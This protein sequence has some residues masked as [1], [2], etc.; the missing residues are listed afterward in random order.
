[1]RGQLLDHP[2]IPKHIV[3]AWYE[4]KVYRLF[5]PLK[6]SFLLWKMKIFIHDDE[7]LY[8][9]YIILYLSPSRRNGFSSLHKYSTSRG[10]EYLLFVSDGVYFLFV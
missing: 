4:C 9:R 1:M 8:N 3:D 7:D 2:G 10:F 6:C 5:I